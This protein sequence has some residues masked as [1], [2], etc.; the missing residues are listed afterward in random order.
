MRN[1]QH[2]QQGPKWASIPKEMLKAMHKRDNGQNTFDSFNLKIVG[3]D[4]MK[5]LLHTYVMFLIGFRAIQYLDDCI[6]AYFITPLS[7]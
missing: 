3:I 1:F 6:D 5:R 2:I 7:S 4:H